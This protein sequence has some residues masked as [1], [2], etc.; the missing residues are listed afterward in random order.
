MIKSLSSVLIL[1]FAFTIGVILG[2]QNSKPQTKVL[3]ASNA[4]INLK[5]HPKF[6]RTKKRRQTKLTLKKESTTK[7]I[8]TLEKK[9]EKNRFL[10]TR[11]TGYTVLLS[12][13]KLEKNAQSYAKKIA[14][15]GYDAF[16]F[17]KNI[18][19][20]TWHRVG[21]GS[22]STKTTAESLK[23]QLAENRLGKGSVIVKIP[24]RQET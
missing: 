21:I 19:G 10:N 24:T 11:R 17:S 1:C 18:R 12:S 5:P 6:K 4:N 22:F 23:K 15:K 20:K 9:I 8:K 14:K 2:A 3:Y 7:L 16:Y 13:F